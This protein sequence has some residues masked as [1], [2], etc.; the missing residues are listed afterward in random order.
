MR[1][2]QA[3]E[4]AEIEAARNFA[5]LL[6]IPEEVDIVK[7]MARGHDRRWHWKMSEDMSWAVT[8]LVP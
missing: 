4:N 8:E 6:V 2:V 3:G 5:L 1:C 7:I